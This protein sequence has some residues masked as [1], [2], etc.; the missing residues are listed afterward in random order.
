MLQQIENNMSNIFIIH[1]VEGHPGE[2]WFPWLQR[3]LEVLGHRVIVPQFPTPER[4]TL[5]DWLVVFE[6]YKEFLTPETVVVGHS[7]G[8]AFLLNIIEKYP[9]KAAFFASGFAEKAGNHFDPSMATFSQKAFDW[10]KI[11]NNCKNFVIFHGDND[12]YIKLQK[13]HELAGILGVEVN[14]IKNGG[15]FNLAAGYDKFEALLEKMKPLLV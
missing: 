10:E 2:N 13:A 14:V 7:L 4:Q 9:V 5:S 15:H 3:E 11:K 6:K 1:G 8:A 12:P